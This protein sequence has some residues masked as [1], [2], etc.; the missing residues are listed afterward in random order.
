M[1]PK[2]TIENVESLLEGYGIKVGYNLIS[3]EFD[4]QIPGIS[5]TVDNYQN[6]V[7]ETVNSLA[8][9]N[10][11]NITQVPRYVA[12][13]A[14][15]NPINPVATWITSRPWDGKDR[16]PEFC[17]TLTAQRDYPDDFKKILMRK[18]SLSAVAAATSPNGFHSRGILTLQGPQGCGKTSWVRS[19]VPEGLL[20]DSVILTGHHLDPSNKD[21]LTTAIKHWI[22][23]I[24]E[25]DSSFKKD[26]ARLKG[27]I[28][29]TTDKI[30]RPYARTDSEYSRR[31]VFAATVNEGNFLVDRTGNSRFWVLPV[32]AVDYQHDVDMQQLFAQLKQELDAGAP[33]WLTPEEEGRLEELNRDHR[34]VST[35]EEQLIAAFDDDLPIDQ[36]SKMSATEVLK[37]VGYHNP[38]NNQCRECGGILREH[39]GPPKKNNGTMKWKVPIDTRNPRSLR[40]QH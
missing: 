11:M 39:F 16:L 24:G 26:I 30:R 33:W 15:R 4:I 21:S 1:A 17:E 40:P 20:R 6:T 23:E 10:D 13:L 31:T 28:T 19:L 29:D 14:D 2:C 32:T 38:N 22:C 12:V 37:C 27:F 34:A 5:P 25:L 36:W 3:K 7:I 8:A 18:W 9:L 35:L